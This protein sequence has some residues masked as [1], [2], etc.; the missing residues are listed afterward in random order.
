MSRYAAEDAIEKRL[1]VKP[2]CDCQIMNNEIENR[3]K[4]LANA[5]G[6]DFGKHGRDYDFF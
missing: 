2:E 1:R 6:A 5:F 3:R 4:A